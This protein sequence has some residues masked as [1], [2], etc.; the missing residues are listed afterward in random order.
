MCESGGDLDSLRAKC[1]AGSGIPTS[2]TFPRMTTLSLCERRLGDVG[3]SLGLRVVLNLNAGKV[4]DACSVSLCVP[5]TIR[6]VAPVSASPAG[7]FALLVNSRP[8]VSTIPTHFS[9]AEANARRDQ[10]SLGRR[11]QESPRT[12]VTLCDVVTNLNTLV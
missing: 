1:S 9:P 2:G 3:V 10:A 12:A 4:A 8:A 5:D 7:C 6:R 11:Q